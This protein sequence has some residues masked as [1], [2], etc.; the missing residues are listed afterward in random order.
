MKTSSLFLL[1]LLITASFALK[2]QSGLIAVKS[3][4]SKVGEFFYRKPR[5]VLSDEELNELFGKYPNVILDYEIT[6]YGTKSNLNFHSDSIH[7]GAFNN[8]GKYPPLKKGEQ[9]HEFVFTTIENEQFK[10]EKLTGKYIIIRFELVPN[11]RFFNEKS[12]LEI[13]SQVGLLAN[14]DQVV[15]FACFMEL[16]KN[17]YG[18]LQLDNF[19]IVPGCSLFQEKFGISS[20]P[21]TLIFDTKGKL[22]SS[23]RGFDSIDLKSIIK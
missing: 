15:A 3:S 22:L 1:S 17:K 14:K 4:V 7:T 9:M 18:D 5:K 11:G 8:S 6:K 13:D 23:Y 19:K 21:T 2:A 10:S 16:D 20:T 12:L